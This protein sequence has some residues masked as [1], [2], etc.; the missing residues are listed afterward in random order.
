VA[1][2][3]GS[4]R[5]L[6]VNIVKN[7]CREPCVYEAT[8]GLEQGVVVHPDVLFQGLKAGAERG[9]LGGLGMESHDLCCDSGVVD[10]M[11][12]LIYEFL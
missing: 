10:H 2:G 4:S 8:M 6:C 7:A 5:R 11:D 12:M 3:R 1:T 9:T